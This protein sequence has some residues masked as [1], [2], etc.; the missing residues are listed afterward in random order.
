[1]IWCHI[2]TVYTIKIQ[3]TIRST[4]HTIKFRHNW[5]QDRI[6]LD[7]GNL[8]LR[9]AC[10]KKKKQ[11]VFFLLALYGH[12]MQMLISSRKDTKRGNEIQN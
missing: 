6:G 1:M 9:F 5:K 4:A 3:H 12:N 10:T 11:F 8:Q 7:V 2:Y